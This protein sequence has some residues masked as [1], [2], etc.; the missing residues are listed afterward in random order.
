MRNRVLD[1][2]FFFAC[3]RCGL[4]YERKRLR[5]EPVTRLLVCPNDYD[6]P[7]VQDLQVRRLERLYWDAFDRL[8]LGAHLQ[9]L[10]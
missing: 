2:D 3:Q 6:E 1:H 4:L 7:T 10:P 8:G 5:R 9:D